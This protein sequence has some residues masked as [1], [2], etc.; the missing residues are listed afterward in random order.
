MAANVNVPARNL[1]L[2]L[3]TT[4]ESYKMVML[5]FLTFFP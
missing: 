2:S 5:T 4:D 3:S 1:L